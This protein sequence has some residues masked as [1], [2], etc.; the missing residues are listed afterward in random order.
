[1]SAALSR[2]RLLLGQLA[3]DAEQSAA[4]VNTSCLAAQGIY[5]RSCAEACTRSALSLTPLAGGLAHVAIDP[6]ACNACGECV[7]VCPVSAIQ[8]PAQPVNAHG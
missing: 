6:E 7:E 4:T 2:R 8:V 1:M 5:C 3:R